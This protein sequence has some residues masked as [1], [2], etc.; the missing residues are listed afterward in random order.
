MVDRINAKTATISDYTKVIQFYFLDANVGYRI[1]IVKGKVE[2]VNQPPNKQ[3]K[4][5]SPAK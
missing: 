1:K 3:R 4:S 2:S 5:Q